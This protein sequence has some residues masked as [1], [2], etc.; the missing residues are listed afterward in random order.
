MSED[1]LPPAPAWVRL[2]AAVIRRL[3]AGRYRAIHKL[4]RPSSA[5]LMHMPEEVGGYSF[6]C[7]LR[8]SISREVC[9][10]GHYEPQETALVKAVLRPGMSF[11]DV[12]AN[13]GYYTLLAA[14]LVGTKGRVLS[15]EPDPRLFSILQRNVTRGGLD[16]VMVLQIAAASEP[17]TLSL[18]GYIEDGG[19]FGISRIAPNSGE[20]EKLFQ[21]SAQ[22]LDNILEQQSLSSVDLMKMDIEGAEVFALAGL[23]KSLIRRKVKRLLLELHPIQLAEHGSSV[24]SVVE[25]LQ[26]AGY[27]P[28]TIDHS[29]TGTRRAAYQKDISL[30]ALIRP[31]EPTQ[32][33]DPWPHQL[34][35]APGVE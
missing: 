16:Q 15:L 8:D 27:N 10:T 31:F 23:E 25:K 13:W 9:F 11:V 30:E 24:S 22:S 32:Q 3:P 34:W 21:V 4:P 35:L 20:H 7:D 33:Y 29:F 28:W 26:S 6:H 17:G 1:W 18:A 14:G 19:N 2:S 5:F 12:G